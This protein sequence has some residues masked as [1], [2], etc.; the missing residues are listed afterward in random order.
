RQIN[1]TRQRPA[2]AHGH[3]H[4]RWGWFKNNTGGINKALEPLYA[5]KALVPPMT[6]VDSTAP[7]APRV[8]LQPG[9][10]G[11]TLQWQNA[12]N[13]PIKCW[14]VYAQVGGKWFIN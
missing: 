4:F 12:A 11:G 9:E 10:G 5:S 7:N 14:V 3:I 1:L 6:W 2:A 13:E 8:M